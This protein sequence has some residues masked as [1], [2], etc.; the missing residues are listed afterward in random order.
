[1]FGQR[2]YDIENDKRTVRDV[3]VYA[4][5]RALGISIYDLLADT[6]EILEED[7]NSNN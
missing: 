2:I 4:L 7:R 6:E 5:A 3:E 1:M